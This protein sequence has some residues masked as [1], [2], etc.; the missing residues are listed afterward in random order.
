[1]N[2]K[3]FLKNSNICVAETAGFC[4]G[5]ANAVNSVNRIIDEGKT[6]IYTLGPIIHNEF[7]I[8]QLESKGVKVIDTPEEAPE[9]AF[10][11]IRAHGVGEQTIADLKAKKCVVEDL[12]CPFVKKIHKLVIEKSFLDIPQKPFLIQFFFM[13]LIVVNGNRCGIGIP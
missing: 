3:D 8:K 10:V 7:I 9:G 1:M 2:Y 4:Y 12:T 13:H 11:V 5:V 6:E